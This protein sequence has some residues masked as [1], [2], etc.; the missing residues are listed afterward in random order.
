MFAEALL[1]LRRRCDAPDIL[2]LLSAVFRLHGFVVERMSVPAALLS[3]GRPKQNLR[4]VRETAAAEIRWRRRLFPHDIVQYP[5]AN[6]LHCK[7]DAQIDVQRAAYPNG[8]V[9]FENA[10]AG[11]QP[12]AIEF[13][14]QVDAA[15]S[16]PVALVDLD[17]AAGDAGDPVVRQQIGGIRPD[18]I[19]AA[20]R[21]LFHEF[22]AVAPIQRRRVLSGPTQR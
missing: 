19:D 12:R 5:V 4:G 6:L 11:G 13:M 15:A 16:V 1:A 10:V 14:V 21:Y 9:R 17:H 8:P 22:E 18:T 3:L 2:H 7:T 20:R